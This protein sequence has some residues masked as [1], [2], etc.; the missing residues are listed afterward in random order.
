[1]DTMRDLSGA[2][3]VPHYVIPYVLRGAN[4][5]DRPTWATDGE[6]EVV[7]TD[8]GELARKVLALSLGAIA[9]WTPGEGLRRGDAAMVLADDLPSLDAIIE[10]NARATRTW[11]ELARQ[12]PASGYACVL[13]GGLRVEMRLEGG[14]Q[15]CLDL[16][17]AEGA[18][19]GAA[20]ME[21]Q[22]RASLELV[23]AAELARAREARAD[24]EQP[25]RAGIRELFRIADLL[26][27]VR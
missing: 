5:G 20:I 18:G 23:D 6:G 8:R 19:V 4:P 12:R 7:S 24:R 15:P 17:E 3:M 21:A 10:A 1:M 9:T 14:G 25:G 16:G 27:G 11:R 26:D 22:V 13:F 2:P